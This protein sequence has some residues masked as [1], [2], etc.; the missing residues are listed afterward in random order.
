MDFFTCPHQMNGFPFLLP[1]F[2]AQQNSKLKLFLFNKSAG[3]QS[4]SS[5]W[6]DKSTESPFCT[7]EDPSAPPSAATVMEHG[8]LQIRDKNVGFSST[9]VFKQCIGI[10]SVPLRTRLLTGTID[11]LVSISAVASPST[12]SDSQRRV[13]NS[14]SRSHISE[15]RSKR[16]RIIGILA[17]I[18]EVTFMVSMGEPSNPPMAPSGDDSRIDPAVSLATERITTTFSPQI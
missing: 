7:C 15:E 10:L 6:A 3:I 11:P 1:S 5:T 18:P 8:A 2:G 4:A 13:I 9:M 14:L 17:L 12:S 16:G